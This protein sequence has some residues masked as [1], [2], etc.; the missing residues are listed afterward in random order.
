MV[1]QPIIQAAI[2][3]AETVDG[4]KNK[5]EACIASF[6]NAAQFSGHNILQ[7]A[8]PKNGKVTTHLSPYTER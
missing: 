4:N 5:F 8:F 2:S 3:S 1:D 7:I 6:E